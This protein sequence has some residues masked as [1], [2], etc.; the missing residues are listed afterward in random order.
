MK[1]ENADIINY[2]YQLFKY[3]MIKLTDWPW[4][5]VP[6]SMVVLEHSIFLHHLYN[7]I[8]LYYMLYNNASHHEFNED[9]GVDKAVPVSSTHN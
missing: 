9:M 4:D 8:F 5:T 2:I 3:D 7:V 1:Y 6:G